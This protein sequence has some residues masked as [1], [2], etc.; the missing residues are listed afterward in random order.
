MSGSHPYL[1]YL[2]GLRAIAILA[3][4][5]FHDNTAWLAGGFLGVEVFFVISGFIITRQLL[6]QW[7]DT[8]DI[9][10]R[11]F[12][13]HRL[14]RLYPGI[15]TMALT[16]WVMVFFFFPEELKQVIEDLPY[17]FT[18]TSNWDYIFTKHSYFETIGRPR[19]FQHLWQLGVQIQYYLIWPVLCL[20][21][22]KL[23]RSIILLTVIFGVLLSTWWMAHLYQP[24]ADPSRVYFGTDTR[25]SA[26]LVGSFTA[27]TMN[28]PQSLLSKVQSWTINALGV[29]AFI[30]L[31]MFFVFAES[32]NDRLFQ[33]GFL[34][35]SILT[36]VIIG[37]SLVNSMQENQTFMVR[38]LSSAPIRAIGVR[39]FSIYIW[40]WPIF[41]LT[42]P[43]V[44]IQMDGL[45][46]FLFRLTLTAVISE[47]FYR[48]IETPV[49]RGVIGQ[50][51]QAFRES[52]GK[53]RKELAVL[54]VTTGCLVIAGC[55]SLVMVTQQKLIA[56][57]NEQAI[58]E[59]SINHDNVPRI[60]PVADLADVQQIVLGSS[61][62]PDEN[63]AT[64]SP[65]VPGYVFDSTVKVGTDNMSNNKPPKLQ[66]LS[67]GDCLGASSS[68][69]SGSLHIERG[70][71]GKGWVIR[72]QTMDTKKTPV[73]AVGDS[74]MLGAINELLEGIPGLGLDA[75]VGRQV[76]AG[77]KILI[78]RRDKHILGDIVIVHL[79][80]N[81]PIGSQQIDQL[82]QV[83]RDVKLVIFVNLKVPRNY[84]LENNRLIENAANKYS[85]IT[86]VDWR[87]NSLHTN[88]IFGKDGIHLT[89]TGARLYTHLLQESI[90]K[91]RKSTHR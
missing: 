15:I 34:C 70:K 43:W 31:F 60:E 26:L 52:T 14:R 12:W 71:E 81:G 27:L 46:L 29:A 49:R 82:M 90:C 57:E 24:G 20:V 3:I 80:N 69:H 75:Q 7:L 78:E 89:G 91:G 11:R 23:R 55:S 67:R 18:F 47:I 76:T 38:I 72:A 51:I 87:E 59:N 21:L 62:V 42:Q 45:P 5:I 35:V 74:V 85:K 17:G 28:Y 61:V 73:F 65:H 4:L 8:H 54:W 40:H 86:I 16:T 83:L 48:F 22:F 84:E 10:L 30:G 39:A 53:R 56:Q 37:T 6:D 19:L 79:G 88:N 63:A 58:S 64:D 68:T 44:D 50:A 13:N 32:T 33:G 25:V 36:A 66:T 1:H 2:D 41:C 77:N 9:D